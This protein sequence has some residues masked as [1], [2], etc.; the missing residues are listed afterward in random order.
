MGAFWGHLLEEMMQ[1][2]TAERKLRREHRA[3]TDQVWWLRRTRWLWVLLGL[4][5]GSLL[6][7]YFF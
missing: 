1:P 6:G 7:W 2:E 3:L 5:S 4:V